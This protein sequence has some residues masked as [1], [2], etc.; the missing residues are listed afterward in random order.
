MASRLARDNDCHWY[1]IP[2]GSEKEFDR[3]VSW[4]EQY[5]ETDYSGRDFNDCRID[6]PHKLI[7]YSCEYED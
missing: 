6:N 5:R 2:L 1:L 4:E 3:W 7:I